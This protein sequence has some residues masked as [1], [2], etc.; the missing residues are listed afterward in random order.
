VVPDP[1][2]YV[3]IHFPT[4]E[5]DILDKLWHI[6]DDCGYGLGTC[7]EGDLKHFHKGRYKLAQRFYKRGEAAPGAS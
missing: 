2:T 1:F 7:V 3:A 4:I 6:L 5:P